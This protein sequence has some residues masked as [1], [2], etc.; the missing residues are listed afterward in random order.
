MGERERMETLE[1]IL[2]KIKQYRGVSTEDD[3]ASPGLCFSS[4]SNSLYLFSNGFSCV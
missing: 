1:D 4:S 3:D 2:E